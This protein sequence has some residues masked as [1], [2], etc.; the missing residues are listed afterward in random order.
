MASD[1]AASTEPTPRGWDLGSSNSDLSD[2][3]SAAYFFLFELPSRYFWNLDRWKLMLFLLGGGAC[4]PSMHMRRDC[5]TPEQ[6]DE[7]N[8]VEAQH[9]V[10]KVVSGPNSLVIARVA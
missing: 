8:P 2:R 10:T 6:L 5:S 9:A 1:S 3:Q 4:G 7:A